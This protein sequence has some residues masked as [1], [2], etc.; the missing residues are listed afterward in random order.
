[1]PGLV[2]WTTGQ[3][4]AVPT[5]LWG[6]RGERDTRELGAVPAA[7][8][9]KRVV[10]ARITDPAEPGRIIRINLY[11]A[12]RGTYLGTTEVDDRTR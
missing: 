6:G 5:T 12:E 4:A 10:H 8:D 2:S 11:D 9:D 1:V 7:G 3:S